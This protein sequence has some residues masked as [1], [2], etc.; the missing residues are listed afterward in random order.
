MELAEVDATRALDPVDHDVGGVA[1]D[2]RSEDGERNARDCGHQDEGDA[3]A[4]RAH[5]V[6]EAPHRRT[7]VLRAFDRHADAEAAPAVT[8]TR[9]AAGRGLCGS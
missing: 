8:D 7:E 2:A 4:L 9:P 6:G 3:E 5:A 1:Q